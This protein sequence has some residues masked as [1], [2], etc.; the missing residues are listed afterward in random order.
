MGRFDNYSTLGKACIITGV[1]SVILIFII[2]FGSIWFWALFGMSKDV[3][4]AWMFTWFG[5]LFLAI[6]SFAISNEFKN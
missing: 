6:I 5:L 4:G 1:V 2:F 3:G